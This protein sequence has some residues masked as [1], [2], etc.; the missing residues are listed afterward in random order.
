MA[1]QRTELGV[2]QISIAAFGIAAVVR[3]HELGAEVDASSGT[4]I[5][6]PV[7]EIIQLPR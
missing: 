7:P 4:Y 5:R 3:P 6:H 2:G 1:A